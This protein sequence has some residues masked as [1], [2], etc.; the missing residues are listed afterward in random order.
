MYILGEQWVCDNCD[1]HVLPEAIEGI[2]YF[3]T[4]GIVHYKDG[5]KCRR[6]ISVKE[7]KI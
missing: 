5:F 7:S 1:A 6:Y 3:Q 4:T 2:H